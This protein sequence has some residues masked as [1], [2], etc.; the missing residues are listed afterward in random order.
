M[1]VMMKSSLKFIRFFLYTF[2]VLISTLT[3]YFHLFKCTL[4]TS[5]TSTQKDNL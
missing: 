1:V 4:G 2:H 5:K 3:L